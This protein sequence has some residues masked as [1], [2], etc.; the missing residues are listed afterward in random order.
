MKF[1][2]KCRQFKEYDE[3]Y[4]DKHSTD[5]KHHKCKECDKKYSSYY[6]GAFT[7]KRLKAIKKYQK[8]IKE[9]LDK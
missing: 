8:R 1:C 3:F 9:K 5:G 4:K 2:T 7:E 6:Y